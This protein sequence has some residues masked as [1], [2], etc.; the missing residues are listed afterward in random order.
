MGGKM[1]RINP[2]TPG[3]GIMPGYLAGR[4][5]LIEEAKNNIYSLIHGYPRQPLIYYGLRGV[6]KTVLLNQVM[7]YA[8]EQNVIT[9]SIEVK[10]RKSLL[11]D[12]IGMSNKILM[13]LS[14][15]EKL[16]SVLD[17]IKK[18]IN[19]FTL[20][21][22]KGDSSLSLGID[23][24]E[25]AMFSI[26]LTDLFIKLGRLAQESKKVIIFFIDEIQYA[27]QEE[28]EA[29]ITAQHRINQERL[30]ISI[31]GAGLP[32]I[33]ITMTQSKTYAERMFSF[34]EITS[35]NYENTKEA[36]LRPAIPFGI[37]YTE[38]AIEEI[39]KKTEGYPY[40]VQQFCQIILDNSSNKITINEVDKSID[41]FYSIL[42]E[43]FYKTRYNKCTI[44]EKEFM[45][46]MVQCGELP[47]TIANVAKNMKKTVKVIQPLRARLIG[48]G[49][50]Y[51]TSYGEI[52]FTVP[53]FD[54]F[55]K[56]INKQI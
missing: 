38:E 3:A 14:T 12:L 7:K 21:Y 53:K 46:A 26:E 40:F 24:L 23:T 50:I 52:D 35:L 47:C 19:N 2:Y 27:K 1:N 39:Y 44:K 22:V 25:K 28:L 30:P 34:K 11:V 4:E 51:S 54:E 32:K 16:K 29:L 49:L 37:S 20:T 13:R 33:L 45:F 42:D 55:L 17:E 6:G 48:K 31:F 5:K 43:G 8:E 41:E 18:S 36:I 10:E 9:C 56:R 15:T